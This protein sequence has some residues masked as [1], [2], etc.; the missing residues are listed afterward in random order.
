MP[1]SAA[2]CPYAPFDLWVSVISL[3]QKGHGFSA[4]FDCDLEASRSTRKSTYRKV[5]RPSLAPVRL[6]ECNRPILTTRAACVPPS[7]RR[8]KPGPRSLLDVVP[9]RTAAFFQSQ[10]HRWMK[11]PLCSA[12][13]FRAPLLFPRNV[14]GNCHDHDPGF[15][16]LLRTKSEDDLNLFSISS[17]SRW[18]RPSSPPVQTSTAVG[19]AGEACSAQLPMITTRRTP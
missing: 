14:S 7:V 12:R 10:R 4:E 16:P 19:F 9:A 1:T 3:R 5:G 8:R 17:L 13:K 15:F 18:V 6:N 11:T 2:G